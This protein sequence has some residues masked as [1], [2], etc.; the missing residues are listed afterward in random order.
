MTIFAFMIKY[1][2]TFMHLWKSKYYC[3]DNNVMF[4]LLALLKSYDY[5]II[6]CK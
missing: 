2:E 5:K 3:N 6:A 4:D 1:D